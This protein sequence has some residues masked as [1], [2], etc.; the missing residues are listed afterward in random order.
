MNVR[1]FSIIS[2]RRDSKIVKNVQKNHIIQRKAFNRKPYKKPNERF[3]LSS[4]RFRLPEFNFNLRDWF[5]KS[6][7]NK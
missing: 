2:P 3:I 5:I 6:Y 1:F 4:L 7:M